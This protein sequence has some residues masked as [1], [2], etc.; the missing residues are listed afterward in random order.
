MNKMILKCLF[1]VSVILA[2]INVQAAVPE[3]TN[4]L[5]VKIA[6]PAILRASNG[7]YT[8]YLAGTG[9]QRYVSDDMVNWRQAGRYIDLSTY[10]TYTGLWASELVEKDGHYYYY[11]CVPVDSLGKRAIFVAEADSPDDTFTP[12]PFPSGGASWQPVLE[13]PNNVSIIDPHVFIDDDGTPYMF[14]TR[15]LI[16]T[17]TNCKID[18]VRL[19]QNMYETDSATTFLMQP[20]QSWEKSWQEGVSVVKHNSIYYLTWSSQYWG[21][22]KYAI[23]YATASNPMGPYTKSPYNPLLKQWLTYPQYTNPNSDSPAPSQIDPNNIG[24]SSPGHNGFALSPDGTELFICYHTKI[25]TQF[26]GQRQMNIDRVIFTPDNRMHIDQSGNIAPIRE[27]RAYPS[28]SSYP[29]SA[30]TD[31]FE[32]TSLDRSLWSNIWAENDGY[33]SVDNGSL[34]ITMAAGDIA[35]ESTNAQNIFLQKAPEGDWQITAK[36][37]LPL[38]PNAGEVEQAYIVVFQ[39]TNNYI[40]FRAWKCTQGGFWPTNMSYVDHIREI[41]TVLTYARPNIPL[42]PDN[43]Y[44]RIK[45]SSGNYYQ[46]YLSTDGQTWDPYGPSYYAELTDINVGMGANKNGVILSAYQAKYDFFEIQRSSDL[47]ED[48]NVNFVD[49]QKI[50]LEWFKNDCFPKPL[51]DIDNNCTVDMN[52]ISELTFKWLTTNP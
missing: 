8:Y 16:R 46:C 39:D 4:P 24:F 49:F 25:G 28:G 32:G 45:K 31:E 48:G 52:D 2:F 40:M 13:L 37:N 3:Y 15:D 17:G 11:F 33:W 41:K 18:V 47:N 5:A 7:D 27:P 23:G 12:L 21:G 44:L 10:L 1:F 29:H 9:T 50:A 14:Y 51:G 43:F 30:Q 22:H 35:G 36:V 42:L 38:S 26:E 6:D 19:K 34:N 20:S